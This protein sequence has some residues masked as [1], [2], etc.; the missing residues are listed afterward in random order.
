MK[1]LLLISFISC[2]AFALNAQSYEIDQ[3]NGQTI[4]ACSGFFYDSG[5]NVGAY[6]N[7]ENYTITFCPSTA[8]TSIKI[9]FTTFQMGNGDQLCV[10]DGINT[11]APSFG[12]FSNITPASAAQASSTNTTGCLTFQFTSDNNSI[13]Q[14][15]VGQIS[16]VLPCQTVQA[17]LASSNPAANPLI[18][19]YIEVCPGDAVTF[20]GQGLYPQNNTYYWQQD[21]TSSFEWIIEGQTYQG[22]N[23][24]Y[25]FNNPGGYTVQLYITDSLGCPSTNLIDQKVRVA[26]DPHFTGTFSNVSTICIGDTAVLTGDVTPR[27]QNFAPQISRGDSIFLPDGVGVCYETTLQLVDFAPGQTLNSVNDLID[28]CVNMEHSFM[29]DLNITIECPNGTVATLHQYSGGGGTY[30]GEPIDIDT[31]LSPGLGY[32]YCWTPGASQTWTQAV[33]SGNTINVN[34]AQTLPPGNYAS[35]TPLT[36][37]VGCPLNGTWEIEICDNLAIDNGYIFNWGIQFNPAIY[38]ALDSFRA[39]VTQQTWNI[40]PSVIVNQGDTI[41][42]T[43]PTSAGTASYVFSATNEFGCTY[44]TTINITVLPFTDVACFDCDTLNLPVLNDLTLCEGDT[45]FLDATTT[46]TFDDLTYAFTGNQLIPTNT[47]YDIP[48]PVSGV[49]GTTVN[50]N[51]IVSVCVDINHIFLQDV[52]MWLVAP[53]GAV[54]ELSTDNGGAGANYTG[55]CFTS[56]ATTNITAGAP[57]F[58]GNFQPEGNWS[59]LFGSAINGTWYLRV[60]DDFAGFDGYVTSA[61]ITFTNPYIVN[62]T[63]SPANGLSCTNCPNPAATPDTTTTYIVTA[64]DNLGC[65][66]SD[67]FTITVENAPDAP[68]ATCGT[69]SAVTLEI[70]WNAVPN[71]SGYEV[72]ING[73]GWIAANN[74]NSHNFNNLSPNTTYQ[75]EVRAIGTA[76]CFLT[77]EIDTIS[78]TTLACD[79][80]IQVDSVQNVSCF[81]GSNGILYLSG[82][83]SAS[84][85]NYN[86][87]GTIYNTAPITGLSAGLYTIIA[88]DGFSCTDTITQ[89]ITEPTDVV[90]TTD[91]TD[92]SCFNGNDGTATVI[93][94]GGVGNYTYA[95]NTNPIQTT[96]TATGLTAGTYTV[97]VADGNNCQKIAQVVVPE[98]TILAI[99]LDKTDALC[100]QSSDGKAWVTATG[101]I[102]NYTYAWNTNPVQITDTAFNIMAGTYT[103]SV[104]DANNCVTIDSIVVG[105]PNELIVTLDSVDVSCFAAMDGIVNTTVSGG[106]APFTYLWNTIPAQDSSVA[107]NLN[108]GNYTVTVTDANGCSTSASIQVNEPT[109]VNAT[110]TT[111][112]VTCFGLS[113]GDATVF[114]SGG[115][116]MGYTYQ[117]LSS[118]IQTTQQAV[119]LPGG[120]ISCIVTDS[121]GCS[122]TLTTNVFGPVLVNIDT[123]Y[124][125]P[126]LCYGSNEGTVGTA[127][128]GGTGNLTYQWSNNGTGNLQFNLSAGMYSMTLTDFV[129]CQAIDSVEVLQPDSIEIQFQTTPLL[130]N[131]DATGTATASVI[132]GTMP[133]NYSWNSQPIQNTAAA[134]NLQ[135]G[136]YIL[137]ITDAN[138]CVMT[139]TAMVIE[140][141]ALAIVF[142]TTPVSCF[143]AVDGKAWATASGGVGNYSYLWN[144][145]SSTSDTINNVTGGFYTIVVSDTNNCILTDSVLVA[146]PAVLVASATSVQT[147]CFGDTDGTATIAATG[148]NGNYTYNWNTT[149]IQNTQTATNL[150]GGL[151]QFTVTDIKNCSFTNSVFVLEPQPLTSTISGTDLNCNGIPDGTA[152]VTPTA[153]TAPY[154]YNWNTTT[155]TDSSVSGLNIGWH[156]VTVTDAFG[157]TVMDSVFLNQPTPMSVSLSKTDVSCNGGNDGTANVV[158]SGG[159]GSYTYLWSNGDTTSTATNVFAGWAIVTV[160]DGNGCTLVDSIELLEPPIISLTLTSIA[161]NC[162]GGND[163]TATV[164]AAGGVGGF[165]YAWNTNPVQ[166]PT[167]AVNL[168]AGTYTVSVT[169]LNNCIM[170]DSVIVNEPTAPVSLSF[171]RV[172]PSCFGFS[173]GAVS[174]IATG[175]TPSSSGY[176]YAWNNSPTSAVNS[177]ITAGI[178]TVTVTDS[179]GCIAIDTV[180]LLEPSP[181][182]SQVSQQQTTCFGGND[183]QAFVLVSGGTPDANNN[184]NIIWGTSP[185]QF[186]TSA[187]GL[188]GGQMYFVTITDNNGC[189]LIDST[190]IGQP[191]PITLVTNH[192]DI[193]CNGFADGTGTITP[194]GGTLP[195]SYL[196]STNANNQDSSTAINLNVGVFAVTV[197]D[198]NG[199]DVTTQVNITEPS[200]LEVIALKEDVICKGDTTGS[201]QTLVAGGIPGYSFEWNNNAGNVS[202]INHLMAGTYTVT[203]TD[204]NGCIKVSNIQIDEPA[205]GIDANYSIENVSCFGERDG[206]ITINPSGGLNPYEF[207]QNG[208]HFVGTNVFIGL[209]A[210]AYPIF[211]RDDWG[212]VFED[213]ITITEPDEVTVDLGEDILMTLGDAISIVPNVQNGTIPYLYAWTPNDSVLS[214]FNCPVPVVQDLQQD[215]RYF[216]TVTDANGCMASDD[217]FVR[218]QKDRVIY[219]ATGFTPNGDGVNDFLY[220]QGHYGSERVVKF[221]IFDRWGEKVF[222]SA[223]TPLN[224]ADLGWDGRFKNQLLNS[225]VFGWRA[226]VLFSDGEVQLYKGNTTLVR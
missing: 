217:I 87:N 211:V 125:T 174:V 198:I 166:T 154:S 61:A 78:C 107:I 172:M 48:I 209:S 177:G 153:G 33:N 30:L 210:G 192:T 147:S 7:N 102:G 142:D 157:C 205:Q 212:C 31:D 13:S 62:Y 68:V 139:D 137:T 221:E 9:D 43:V 108:G 195:Y 173:D 22:Q 36:G 187:A 220:V 79:L 39:E 46:T 47:N 74:T 35:A 14:G 191:N 160:T 204:D 64:S 89:M 27:Q 162:F 158:A 170:V 201:I 95:W 206:S 129:G 193:T 203:V 24:T 180:E 197:T 15:W 124:S 144:Y 37:L 85:F 120:D 100:N 83:T 18:N 34:G 80:A 199:C 146:E 60:S 208:N 94:N 92:V 52:D 122:N 110:F 140:P 50:A 116:G 73:S 185:N 190:T 104:T 38:P 175:G 29:G 161:V 105:E 70:N 128:S 183:G 65:T 130:C 149:P 6:Q 2:L 25:N 81:G 214:C 98:P 163:G 45:A 167:T 17:N 182:N 114:P 121:D 202:N 1:Q 96:A 135:A 84:G 3:F 20:F 115:T 150:A 155:Q 77:S 118:P 219:V 103:V 57:P 11:A 127:G 133:Y 143:G 23:V 76:S 225:G 53:N 63:W 106:T 5:G 12:C 16:C 109:Q 111:T 72:N 169:D 136:N 216:L 189:L 82:S 222:E 40:N 10:F 132:G 186:G 117:W 215:Q 184:Y 168:T 223:D 131:N 19:G 28:I 59:T 194:S 49:G 152:T 151:Y 226:E 200:V 196:W 145:N 71:T 91:S 90:L 93:A 101:G 55:T 69:A 179:L 188:N 148:G 99:T 66:E 42:T 141:P 58:T 134:N 26:E 218:V 75:I 4:N 181:L 165:T 156:F 123:I 51:T 97:T 178:Y 88:T 138:N 44:D 224:Q 119:N 32:N 213:T 41:I 56:T 126:T 54:L 67:T 159:V 113:D 171:G 21:A 112:Q 8:N 164:V 176:S 207:S 86:V